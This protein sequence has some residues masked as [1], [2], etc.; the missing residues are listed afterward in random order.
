MSGFEHT[1]ARTHTHTALS[2]KAPGVEIS[3]LS[4]FFL[5]PLLDSYTPP[6]L[7]FPHIL[8]KNLSLTSLT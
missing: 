3:E 5:S 6:H 8:Q 7:C 2:L 1:C 4:P